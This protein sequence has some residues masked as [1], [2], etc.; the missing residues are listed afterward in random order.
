MFP[1]NALRPDFQE[2]TLIVVLIFKSRKSHKIRN[3]QIIHKKKN[4]FENNL[5]VKLTPN[6]PKLGS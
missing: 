4:E 5:T 1:K 2:V 3:S 6:S